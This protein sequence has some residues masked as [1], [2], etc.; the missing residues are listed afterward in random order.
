MLV[1]VGK[2]YDVHIHCITQQLENQKQ[3]DRQQ[4]LILLERFVIY[5]WLSTQRY[6]YNKNKEYFPEKS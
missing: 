3:S 2:K 6:Q 4:S 1:S 5:F